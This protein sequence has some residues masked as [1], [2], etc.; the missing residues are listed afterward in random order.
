MKNLKSNRRTFIKSSA[1]GALGMITVPSLLTGCVG[2]ESK[3]GTPGNTFIKEDAKGLVFATPESQGVP[4]EAII[5]MLETLESK[6]V[7]MHSFMLLRHGAVVA[8]GYW[9]TF[10]KD[11][12]QRMYSVSKS[13]TS[14]AIGLMITEGKLKLDDKIAD[15]FPE[16]LPANPHP[17]I[18]QATVRDLLTMSTFNPRSVPMQ[19]GHTS[20]WSFLNSGETLRPPG[21]IFAYDTQG[22]NTLAAIVEKKEG[23]PFLEYMR[24][25]I[26]DPIGFSK[27]TYCIQ[28]T[29][30]RS[31][32]GS[33]VLCTA[34]DMARF[35][36]LC[37]NMGAFEGTQLVSK[38]YMQAATSRQIDNTLGRNEAEM[39]YGYGYQFWCLRDGGF[40]GYGMGGQYF[41]CMPKYDTILVTTGDAQ[42]DSEGLNEIL[43]AYMVLLKRVGNSM[44][45]NSLA[46]NKLSSKI[47][48]LTFRLPD[49]QLQ[50]PA[51]SRYNGKTF[52]MENNPMKL[53][54][55][56]LSFKQD[57]ATLDYT[58]ANGK[59]SIR[60]GLGQYLPQSF[61]EP[62]SGKVSGIR[63]TYYDIL[64]AGAWTSENVFMCTVKAVDY[65]LGTLRMQ[66]AF[67]NDTVCVQM[68]KQAEMFWDNYQGVGWG[69]G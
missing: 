68:I 24:P 45:D 30:G 1:L 20:V 21:A 6:Q 7:C 52:K 8:E 43:G 28:N 2:Q 22:T 15:I 50:S 10:N 62:Y 66:F 14:V 60:I 44:A 36:L 33:G 55:F 41:L 11:K 65:Y 34:R 12:F 31:W 51:A 42:L 54:E 61:P 57:E 27:D 17:F 67:Q 46:Q 19:A 26:L 16:D 23:M 64:T 37:M 32:S 5:E 4:S 13:F 38:E 39:K 47:E 40:A 25:K 29:D 9:P 49:G 3:T 48:S 56:R 58:N 59:F 69:R 35:A 53:T 18:L 63:D